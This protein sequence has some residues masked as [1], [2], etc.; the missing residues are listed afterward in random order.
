VIRVKYCDNASIE[1]DSVCI[2]KLNSDKPIWDLAYLQDFS[3]NQSILAVGCDLDVLLYE[4]DEQDELRVLPRHRIPLGGPAIGLTCLPL[5]RTNPLFLVFHYDCIIMYDLH[6]GSEK[7]IFEEKFKLKLPKWQTY[8]NEHFRQGDNPIIS[9]WHFLDDQYSK[10]IIG[11]ESGDL[12]HVVINLAE[13]TL[14]IKTLGSTN[15][16]RSIASFKYQQSKDCLI[17]PGDYSSGMIVVME[18]DNMK[19]KT[20]KII[21]NMSPLTDFLST[22]RKFLIC[23]GAGKHGLISSLQ[24]GME[25]DKLFDF[26]DSESDFASCCGI[27]PAFTNDLKIIAFS[28][29]YETRFLEF[30]EYDHSLEDVSISKD[31]IQ[32]ARTIYFEFISENIL[33]QVTEELIYILNLAQN[34]VFA[35]IELISKI[36]NVFTREING[37]VYIVLNMAFRVLIYMWD[38]QSLREFIVVDSL[39]EISSVEL[40]MQFL[41][42]S[43]Y[44]SELQ[45]WE[46]NLLQRLAVLKQVI[47]L[48]SLSQNNADL[49]I[50]ESVLVI[51]NFILLGYREGILIQLELISHSDL[52]VNTEEPISIRRISWSSIKLISL[53]QGKCAI[54]SKDSLILVEQ[55]KSSSLRFEKIVG[56]DF[57]FASNFTGLAG[58]ETSLLGLDVLGRLQAFSIDKN[59][60]I[61]SFCGNFTSKC[62]RIGMVCINEI[63]FT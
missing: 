50:L 22:S 54:L 36:M 39:S 29:P 33:L 8:G 7:R 15:P 17:L 35:K 59:N 12:F 51:S 25:S 10:L 42:I 20:L 11:L 9:S 30:N 49:G 24:F 48:Q 26:N 61:P 41:F 45:I 1:L 55:W 62:T 3:D 31:F 4:I 37:A 43:T 57:L 53:N 5:L 6:F 18:W 63:Y 28:F 21:R 58:C 23:S 44:S 13:M 14:D 40:N 34:N 38:G 32:N 56:A 19:L 47:D 60:T 46:I 2:V 52:I 16:C 27:Y